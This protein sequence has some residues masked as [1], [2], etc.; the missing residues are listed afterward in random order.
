MP[1][2]SSYDT[3][4]PCWATCVS[5]FINVFDFYAN[6]FGWEFEQLENAQGYVL[7][8]LNG[9]VVAGFSP[10]P[11]DEVAHWN[12]SFCSNELPVITKR[13]LEAGGSTL[14]P[15]KELA[16]SGTLATYRDSLGTI[17]SAWHGATRAGFEE[18]NSNGAYCWAELC[19]HDVAESQR[20]YSQ[21][22]DWTIAKGSHEV[23]DYTLFQTGGKTVA[24]AISMPDQLRSQHGPFWETYFMVPDADVEATRVL[25]LGGE[26][27]HGPADIPEGRFAICSDPGGAAFSLLAPP[28]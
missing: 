10:R 25:T 20:F 27:L 16:A 6:L 14:G 18:V 8:R 3:G 28:D 17:F 23:M 19:S 15:P 12:L 5:D 24:G 13:V 4:R 26:V 2:K 1:I 7:A 22:F 9:N 21:V 11:T